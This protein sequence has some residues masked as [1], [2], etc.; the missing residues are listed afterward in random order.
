MKRERYNLWQAVT[1]A[2][3]LHTAWAKVASNKGSAGGDHVTLYE[4][5]KNLFANLTQLRAELLGGSYRSGPFKRVSIPKKKPGYRILTIPPIRDRVVHTSIASAF[6][7]I[8][9]PTFEDSSFAYRP[10][11][12]V[13]HAVARIEKWRKH[14]FEYVIEADIVSYFDNVNHEILLDKLKAIIGALD[15]SAP[16][17]ALLETILEAQAKA[18]GTPG[19]GIVQGSPLSPILANIYLDALDEEIAEQGVKIVRFADDF[20]ILCKSEKKAKKVLEH[21]VKVLETHNLR[22][23]TDGTRI[24]N[25]DKGFDF[26]GYLFLKSLAVKQKSDLKIQKQKPI[27]STVT[28]EGIIELDEKGSRFDPGKRVLYVLDPSHTL[29]TRNRSFSVLRDDTAELIAVPH[30]RVG[31]LEIGP[32]VGFN[33]HPIDLAADKGVHISLIDGFGQTK[34]TFDP[35]PK[36][37][38]HLQF[39]QA[40]TISKIADRVKIARKLVES[41]MKNQRTQLRRL[42]RRKQIKELDDIF[43]SMGRNLKKLESCKSISELL[44][45]EGATSALYWPALDQLMDKPAG[46]LKKRSRP[47]VDPI[48]ATINYMTGIL[49]RDIRAAIHTV[50][51]HQ[52]FG[53]LHGT[54]NN[55]DGLVFDMMEPFRAPLTEGL[56]VFLFNAN[57]LS[58]DMFGSEN[59]RDVKMDTSAITAIVKA[60]EHAVGKRVRRTNVNQ[61]LT[62]RAMMIQQCR[63]L[64][65]AVETGNS[66]HFTPYLMQA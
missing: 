32:R 18:L 1:S 61:K 2:E 12:G 40:Q 33:R 31:R 34:S 45:L 39:N 55:H 15:G 13:V 58:P 56:P 25:F 7:P 10:G 36:R 37:R 21:C 59:E 29:R 43:Q 51:L 65:Q 49:E 57:R 28:D 16:I 46:T 41:R 62:W 19:Q 42:N 26:I 23:H 53:F 38:A 24:V 11:R 50:G 17:L 52:G 5:Q 54:R 9:E 64:A 63:S 6:T 66:N 47:A 44:G 48:N 4:F 3:A 60:Y 30:K 8:F 35:N 20:V 27:K 14:G 22:L